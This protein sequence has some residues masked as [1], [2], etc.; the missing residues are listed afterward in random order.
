MVSTQNKIFPLKE[1]NSHKI[2]S[3]YSEIVFPGEY[4]KMHTP[5]INVL[6][7]QNRPFHYKILH[8]CNFIQS[9]LQSIKISEFTNAIIQ[10]S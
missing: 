5:I 3:M 7:H 10:I 4:Q 2:P 6:C 8:F 9:K 1:R